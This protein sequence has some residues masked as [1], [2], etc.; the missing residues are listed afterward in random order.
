MDRVKELNDF[1]DLLN[2]V[3]LIIEENPENF[4][5]YIREAPRR[6]RNV[7]CEAGRTQDWWSGAWEFEC[8]YGAE[9]ECS[10][11]CCDGGHLDPRLYSEQNNKKD[12]LKRAR[13]SRRFSTRRY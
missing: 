4:P 6:L 5:H 2:H 12:E 8:G 13:I 3:K 7:P 9:F 11:C 10:E 1:A